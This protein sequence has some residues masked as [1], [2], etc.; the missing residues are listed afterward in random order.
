MQSLPQIRHPCVLAS[1]A[2]GL[3]CAAYLSILRRIRNIKNSTGSIVGSRIVVTH[4]A[5]EHTR[6]EGYVYIR[7]YDDDTSSVL[8]S[9]MA[10][11]W[12]YDRPIVSL[13]EDENAADALRTMHDTGSSCALIYNGPTLIGV[14]DLLD[15]VRYMLR[16]CIAEDISVRKMVR[17][18]I[19][20]GDGLNLNDICQHL[21]TGA[22]HVAITREDSRHTIVSQRSLVQALYHVATHNSELE[23]TFNLCLK[24]LGLPSYDKVIT[25]ASSTTAREAFQK[26]AAYDITSILVMDE[27][28]A[29][30]V[31]SATDILYARLNTSLLDM[32]VME[33]IESSR[34]DAQIKRSADTV[35]CCRLRDRLHDAV[36]LMLS[37]NVH[38]IYVLDE[39]QQPVAVVSFVDVIR[40]I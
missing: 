7:R 35:I 28:G 11:D 10:K 33:Y 5:N 16:G 12:V 3:G 8:K 25:I 1:V 4:D 13:N 6:N 27:S 15:V 40:R 36:S 17:I 34:S 2:F 14:L 31:I 19:V 24:D 39:E 9:M 38:H 22:R 32:D 18:C 26:M 37:N 29:R 23:S 30:G 21:K 20:G